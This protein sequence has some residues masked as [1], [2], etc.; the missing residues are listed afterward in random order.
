MLVPDFAAEDLGALPRTTTAFPFIRSRSP[1]PE[2]PWP[3]APRYPLCRADV[4]F[5]L[6]V[7]VPESD[8]DEEAEGAALSD[9]EDVRRS[10]PA[11]PSRFLC[12]FSDDATPPAAASVEP[13]ADDAHARCD[14]V[15]AEQHDA[16]GFRGGWSVYADEEEK[17][18]SGGRSPTCVSALDSGTCSP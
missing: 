10:P 2:S 11:S 15:F 1:S 5:E 4:E 16:G 6:A 13:G 18:R 12:T 8:V 7:E 14:D 3:R 17:Q 9:D